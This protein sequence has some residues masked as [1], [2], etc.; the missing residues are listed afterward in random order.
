MKRKELVRFID[1]VVKINDTTESVEATNI[2]T[3]ERIEATI[4][5]DERIAASIALT[6]IK[7]LLED[8]LPRGITPSDMAGHIHLAINELKEQQGDGEES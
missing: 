5:K 3:G 6:A 1:E 4:T 2:V 7:L 8:K